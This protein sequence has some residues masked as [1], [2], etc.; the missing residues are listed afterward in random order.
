MTPEM[1]V[2]T[3]VDR[4]VHVWETSRGAAIAIV[5]IGIPTMTGLVAIVECIETI[6]AIAAKHGSDA[7][8]KTRS[9]RAGDSS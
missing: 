6:G 8:D 9:G 2:G 1:V 5:V 7:D 3:D 4:A